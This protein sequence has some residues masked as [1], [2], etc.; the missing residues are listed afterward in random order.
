MARPVYS[1][2]FLALKDAPGLSTY[3]LPIAHTG[4]VRDMV[5]WLPTTTASFFTSVVAVAADSE[6]VFVWDVY[7]GNAQPGVY[8][9]QGRQVF[10]STLNVFAWAHPFSLRVS[11]YALSP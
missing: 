3:T 7:G 11:G 2:C 10:S 9:W 5:L 6:D 4:V 8:H 1:V